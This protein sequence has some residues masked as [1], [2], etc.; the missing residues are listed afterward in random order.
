[1]SMEK[2]KTY[3]VYKIVDL[4]TDEI[5]YVGKTSNFKHRKYY[6]FT[7]DKTPVQKYM[8]EEGRDKFEMTKLIDDIETNDEAVKI[9][10]AYIVDLQPIMNKNRSGNI[11]KDDPKEYYR[12]YQR[13]YYSND[14]DK[15][16]KYARDYQKTDKCREHK[17]EYL[18][19]W[20]A[21]KK[22]EIQKQEGLF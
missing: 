8:L 5:I 11:M 14:I 2:E 7:Q 15:W 1:M 3:C 17:R 16:R 21:M 9:E 19:K 18:R 6:H 22:L 4:R 20:R 13:D 10:D 12:A